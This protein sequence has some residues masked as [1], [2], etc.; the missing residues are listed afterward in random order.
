MAPFSPIFLFFSS[1]FVSLSSHFCLCHSPI[2]IEFFLIFYTIWFPL[3][4]DVHQTGETTPR[5][6]RKLV[7]PITSQLLWFWN[8]ESY[9]ADHIS[10]QRFR[11][12]FSMLR[13]PRIREITAF[14]TRNAEWEYT[15]FVS[16]EMAKNT[17]GIWR[18]WNSGDG[19][20]NFYCVCHAR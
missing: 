12:S 13:N 7:S 4:N 2:F 18:K 6:I 10:N 20:P 15:A 8:G 11:Q 17:N 19:T 9:V 16:A 3:S 5:W 1:F 14:N